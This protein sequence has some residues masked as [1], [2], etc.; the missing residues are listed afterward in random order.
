MEKQMKNQIVV[1]SSEKYFSEYALI[2][3]HNRMQV[4]YLDNVLFVVKQKP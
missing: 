4:L 3:V 2:A 1:A